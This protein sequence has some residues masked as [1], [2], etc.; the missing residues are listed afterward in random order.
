[1]GA[2]SSVLHRYV[3]WVSTRDLQIGKLLPPGRVERLAWHIRGE[4]FDL[5][6]LFVARHI[7]AHRAL[8]ARLF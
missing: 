7:F 1:M 2:G 6:P 5:L 8:L 3:R 4:V